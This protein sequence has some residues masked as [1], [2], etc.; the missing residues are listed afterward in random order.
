MTDESDPYPT[1]TKTET[2]LEEIQEFVKES[3][4]GFFLVIEDDE[5]AEAIDVL[6]NS[7]IEC[8]VVRLPYQRAL[9]FPCLAGKSILGNK[10]I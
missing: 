3:E 4:A 6:K 2:I 8:R 1:F 10:K 9:L 7:G 5:I